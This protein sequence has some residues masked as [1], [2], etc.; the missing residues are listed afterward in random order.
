M[1]LHRAV[2]VSRDLHD[3]T[4]GQEWR[5]VGCGQ[6]TAYEGDLDDEPCPALHMFE[7]E[8]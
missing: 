7:D 4:P 2:P 5:C 1:S 8:P 3:D 6:T